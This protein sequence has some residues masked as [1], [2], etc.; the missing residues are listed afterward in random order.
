MFVLMPTCQ[1]PPSLGLIMMAFLWLS[2]TFHCFLMFGLLELILLMVLLWEP[3][4]LCP[5]L[6]CL[7]LLFSCCC[8]Y[9]KMLYECVYA[10][11]TG[12]FLFWEAGRLG[13]VPS[14]SFRLLFL[15]SLL[16][17]HYLF[18]LFALNTEVDDVD[19]AVVVLISSFVPPPPLNPLSPE[20]EEDDDK[21]KMLPLDLTSQ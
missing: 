17:L 6:H 7:V 20:D 5:V 10:W 21:T 13:K 16:S 14:F 9:K 3:R 11:K 2:I 4:W 12:R 18:L 1:T 8:V 15:L 19:A